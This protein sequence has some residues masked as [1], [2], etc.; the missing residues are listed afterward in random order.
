MVLDIHFTDNVD[1]HHEALKV[2]TG[3]NVPFIFFFFILPQLL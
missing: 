2:L 3:E 1:D